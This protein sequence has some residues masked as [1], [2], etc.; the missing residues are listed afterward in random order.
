MIKDTKVYVFYNGRG[1][2]TR[3]EVH[4]PDGQWWAHGKVTDEGRIVTYL[5]KTSVAEEAKSVSRRGRTKS[6]K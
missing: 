3:T 2:V 5:P 1:E 6:S 4:G